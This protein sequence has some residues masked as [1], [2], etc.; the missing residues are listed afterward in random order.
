MLGEC[1]AVHR[2]AVSS[3]LLSSLA[4]TAAQRGTD[5]LAPRPALLPALPGRAPGSDKKFPVGF[6]ENPA[7]QCGG[8]LSPLL[9]L[10]TFPAKKKQN[11]KK[12]PKPEREKN[13]YK[14]QEEELFLSCCLNME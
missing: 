11:R 8:A 4:G 6:G 1:G 3:R 12:T 14:P 2:D 5:G 13:E 10:P 9:L 7:G